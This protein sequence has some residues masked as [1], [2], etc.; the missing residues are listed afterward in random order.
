MNKTNSQLHQELENRIRF[1][2]LIADISARF[3]SLPFGKVDHEIERALKQILDFFEVDRC[4]LM[5]IREDKKFVWVTHICHTEDIEPVS[6]DI[7]LATLFPWSYEEH[8]IKGKPVV[9]SKMTDLPPE[10]RQDRISWLAQ[11]TRSNLTIPLSSS[12][13]IRYLFAIQSIRRERNW[14]KAFIPRLKLAGEIFV[15]A[16]E[17]RDS[18]Q[19]LSESESHRAR[20]IATGEWSEL[21]T[22]THKNTESLLGF[23]ENRGSPRLV[24]PDDRL[25]LLL[26]IPEEQIPHF[27]EFWVEHLHPDDRERVM[28]LRHEIQENKLNNAFSEY[29]YLHPQRGLLW[30]NHVVQV[31]EREPQGKVQRLIGLIWDVTGYKRLIEAFEQSRVQTLAM[32]N[33]TDDLIW[34]VDAQRFGLLTWNRA[35]R[36]YFYNCHGIEISVGMS[37]G[38]LLPPD[39][40]AQWHEF[41]THA[42]RDG[43]FVTEYVVSSQTKILLLSLH[44]V[45]QGNNVFGISVFG[46]DITHRK[47]A[48]HKLRESEERLNLASDS[49]GIGLWIIDM[50]T[51]HAWVTSKLRELFN[52]SSNDEITYERFFKAIHPEDYNKVRQTVEHSIQTKEDFRIDYRIV[53]PEGKIRWISAR[54]LPYFTSS[55]ELERLMGVSLDITERKLTEEKL[56]ASQK[57]LRAFTSRLLTI[58]EEERRRLARELHDDFTQRLAVLAMELS[59]LEVSAPSSGKTF[60]STIKSVRDQIIELSTDIHDISRQLHP[61]IIDDLGLGR[62]IQS[63]CTH[64]TRR[65]GIRI[66][67]QQIN[68]PRT[69]NR[70]ISV[71]L[72]RITQEALR[73]IHKHAQVE[74]ATVN[75]AGKEDL[76]TLAIQDQGTGFDPENRRQMHGLGLF[77]MQ[78]RVQLIHGHLSIHS[79]RGSGTEIRV[80]VPLT[81]E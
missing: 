2:T 74:E 11:G 14:P 26:G 8:V 46:K 16:L 18:E 59:K 27:Y 45:K 34:S 52:F 25:R 40:A 41:Y 43:S 62:A 5:G 56:L 75:L 13:G 19:A 30:L 22:Q 38:Q 15:N 80:V 31:L 72:F 79:A 17:R 57:V 77:S 42:L 81:K 28:A 65:S 67:Y 73:N 39:Y 63:E 1:E 24:F 3:T 9:V 12:Q 76:I 69:L 58:Q 54:G 7:N 29:R 61:S 66:H 48:E 51:Y 21:L 49:A 36:D 44:V 71:V 55:G 53:L 6:K 50:H 23:Y 32:M 70:D 60:E 4:G 10:A 33:S 20:L 35:L 68:L 37:P 47:Q 64:F 78:E